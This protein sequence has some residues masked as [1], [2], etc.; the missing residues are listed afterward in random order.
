MTSVT[1]RVFDNPPIV[2]FSA[3]GGTLFG[4]PNYWKAMERF[5]EFLP[6]FNDAGG[7]GYS[8]W[9]P[10]APDTPVVGHASGFSWIGGF[11]G[12]S[13]KAKAD[14]VMK[15]FLDDIQKIT[16]IPVNYTSNLFPKASQFYSTFFA[17]PDA[18]GGFAILG[19][20]IV[21]HDKLSSAAGPK[22]VTDA[23]R[24]LKHDPGVAIQGLIVAGGQASRNAG[25]VDSALHP[26]WRRACVEIVVP[27]GWTAS[28]PYSVQAAIQHNVTNVEVPILKAL[29]D[30]PDG[31][32]YLNEADGYD[33]EFQ[34]S[35]WG[36]NYARA[37]K[38]KQK[39]DPK[40][41]FIVRSGV[42]SENWDDEGM[43][44]VRG[45]PQVYNL[46][47]GRC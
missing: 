16:G 35:F 1:L 5:F 14:A 11:G 9:V 21:T 26:V 40:N 18:D 27:R 37:Y 45:A 46:G 19:S 13:D 39:W 31:G 24:S 7:N 6:D 44:R 43:C 8:Y 12:Y 15:P 47:P 29:D 23:I 3:T 32:T 20:R 36:P 38:L 17:T 4:D 28:T 10:D 30:G 42:G 22:Q 34:K 41:L 33:P 2:T 25:K